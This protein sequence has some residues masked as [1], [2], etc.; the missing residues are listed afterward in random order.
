MPEKDKEAKIEEVKKELE[1]IK[2]KLESQKVDEEIESMPVYNVPNFEMFSETNKLSV[3]Y[4]ELIYVRDNVK[5][6]FEK[7]KELQ[8]AVGKPT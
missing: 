6:L 7:V 3:I 1:E 8:I 5:L 2:K 4:N